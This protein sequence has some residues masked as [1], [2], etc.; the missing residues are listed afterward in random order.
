MR[1]GDLHP[2]KRGLIQHIRERGINLNRPHEI[3]GIISAIDDHLEIQL[4]ISGE[5]RAAKHLQSEAN[6]LFRAWVK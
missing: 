3:Q 5:Q 2:V 4:G 6:K 1:S